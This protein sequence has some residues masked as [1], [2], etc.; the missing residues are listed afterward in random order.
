MD[1]NSMFQNLGPAGGAMLTGM[2]MRDT[3]NE[4]ESQ[5][6]YRQAQMDEIMQRTAQQK[7]MNPLD[8]QAKQ[9]SLDT[10]KLALETGGLA[11]KKTQL[12]LDA[13]PLEIQVKNL[14]RS[15]QLL[16]A[17]STYLSTVPPVQ[18]HAALKQY[19]VENGINMN[20]PTIQGLWNQLSSVK[21]EEIPK[22]L[23][24]FRENVMR[25][26]STVYSHLKGLEISGQTSRDVAEIGARSR[27]TIA[28]SKAKA[29][30]I[31]SQVQAGKLSYEKAAVAFSVMAEMAD[32]PTD[33]AKYLQMAQTYE[34]LN[35]NAKN[36][37]SQGKIDPGAMTGLPTINTPPVLGG[38]NAAPTNP[39]NRKPIGQY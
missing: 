3:Q 2:Q 35:L 6:A 33:K 37:A 1:L 5:Q 22:V 21:G 13:A 18:R 38:S 11:N 23:N 29:T 19:A 27:E 14:Q 39:G 34:Q 32:E 30:D 8:L 36:A 16:G 26:E 12:E 20:S 4:Q 10:G 17:A 31:V 28:K 25:Q 24:N 9:Q 7:L 15:S